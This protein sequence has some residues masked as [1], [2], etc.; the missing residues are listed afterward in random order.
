MEAQI[1]ELDVYEHPLERDTMRYLRLVAIVVNVTVLIILAYFWVTEPPDDGDLIW[2]LLWLGY[3]LLNLI[4]LC[5]V[6]AKEDSWLGLYF[7]R[8]RLEE[9]KRIEALERDK[10]TTPHLSGSERDE[11]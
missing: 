4:S 5:F 2:P 8:K 3:I 6:K 9:K 7:K 1:G 11:K 10:D